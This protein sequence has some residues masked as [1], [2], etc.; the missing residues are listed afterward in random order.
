MS[1]QY[2]YA[3]TGSLTCSE[4][5][6]IARLFKCQDV[7]RVVYVCLYELIDIVLVRNLIYENSVQ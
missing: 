4:A 2:K 5:A 7:V 1:K 3:H 6:K